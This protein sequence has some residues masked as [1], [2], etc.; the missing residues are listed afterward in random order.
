[1][2]SKPTPSADYRAQHPGAVRPLTPADELLLA[3]LAP[4]VLFLICAAAAA[5]V[6]A[7]FRPGFAFGS[8]EPGWQTAYTP[9]VHAAAARPAKA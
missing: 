2:L 5:I 7:F 3:A 4:V 1:V 8:D 6:L 9:T